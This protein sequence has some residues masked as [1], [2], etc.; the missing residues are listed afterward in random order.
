MLNGSIGWTW[1]LARVLPDE[2]VATVATAAG[3]QLVVAA[4][5]DNWVPMSVH[6]SFVVQEVATV[7]AA[8]APARRSYGSRGDVAAEGVGDS[9]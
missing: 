6:D 9:R 3:C 8:H 1:P 2:Q 4:G 5:V 7:E